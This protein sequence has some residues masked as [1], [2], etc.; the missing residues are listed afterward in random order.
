MS[1]A[2][3][4]DHYLQTNSLTCHLNGHNIAKKYEHDASPWTETTKKQELSPGKWPQSCGVQRDGVML[5]IVIYCNIIFQK[6]HFRPFSMECKT[7]VSCYQ[8]MLHAPSTLINL[9]ALDEFNP[10][11]PWERELWVFKIFS[12]QD[13]TNQ[14]CSKHQRISSFL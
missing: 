10:L 8:M 2:L 9:K 4:F 13:N 7:R 1:S 11:K 3:C 12:L 5:W 14:M 6:D